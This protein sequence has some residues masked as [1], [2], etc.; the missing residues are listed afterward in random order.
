MN[1]NFYYTSQEKQEIEEQL[2][3]TTA[4][5]NSIKDQIKNVREML[6]IERGSKEKMSITLN[7]QL[8]AARKQIG[9]H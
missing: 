4:Q 8:D 2:A 3:F 1:A 9:G 6:V 5:L 7:C